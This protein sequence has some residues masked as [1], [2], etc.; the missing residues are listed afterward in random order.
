VLRALAAAH[1][2]GVL[3]RDIKPGNVLIADEGRVVLTDFGL[4]TFDGES[5][6]TRPGLVWGSP[7]YVAPERAKHGISS[8]EAD[9]WSLGATLYAAVEGV[10]PY[11]RPTAMASLTAL[12]TEKPPTSQ[13][14]GALKPV[15]TGLLRKDP[16]TR[17]RA[18]EVERIL[19]RVTEDETKGRPRR[20]PRQR[21][22][23]ATAPE[24]GSADAPVVQIAPYSLPEPPP[25]D[26]SAP[27]P[28]AGPQR[29]GPGR[30]AWA[31]VTT[32]VLLMLVVAGAALVRSGGIGGDERGGDR[33]TGQAANPAPS[34]PAVVTATD[35][36]PTDRVAPH[37]G[38]SY[39]Q[40][41]GRFRMVAPLDWIIGH[42][43]TVTTIREPDGPTMITV[44]RWPVP[45][46]GSLAAA[47]ARS[48][49][50]SAGT[51]SA[52][53]NYR[54]VEL[55]PIEYFTG[56]LQWEYTY[57][58]PANGAMRTVSIWFVHEGFCYSFA[59]SLPEHEYVGRTNYI[60]V[61]RGGFQPAGGA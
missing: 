19:L 55:R 59:V 49:A 57:A 21:A 4:A 24:N 48:E 25:A 61:V 58:D 45:A 40:E 6:V 37:A 12:A 43:G 16:R 30:L 23:T 50:W 7:E 34:A 20:L 27:H 32:V 1:S 13:H 11:A 14:A 41:D 5:S 3:H 18:S 33:R 36:L 15:I 31:L 29:R 9:L 47:R 17:L 44:D 54:L 28:P 22:A 46:A 51:D 10:S 52:P 35:T 53:A 2:A 39:Y 8:V 60:E 42:E 56:G 38:W 26:V